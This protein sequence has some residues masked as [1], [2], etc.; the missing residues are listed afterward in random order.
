MP[1]ALRHI[2][3]VRGGRLA[4]PPIKHGIEIGRAQ[5]RL[6]RQL[7]PA[8]LAQVE[9]PERLEGGARTRRQIALGQHGLR[10]PEARGEHATTQVH[11][12]QTGA[13]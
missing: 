11:A 10:G 9:A 2:T 3:L 12:H 7:P 13:N 1:A 4:R 6:Q 5:T 8:M